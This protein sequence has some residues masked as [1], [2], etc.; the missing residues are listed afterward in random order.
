MKRI[1]TFIFALAAFFS[2]QAQDYVIEVGNNFFAPQN[3]VV[4]VGETVQWTNTGGFHNVN[5][6]TD[7]YPDNPEGFINGVASTDAWTFEYTFTVP[8]TYNYQCDPHAG[9]GM[10]GVITVEAAVNNTSDIVITEIMYNS[11][12]SSDLEFIELYNNTAAPIDM[13]DWSFASGFEYVFPATTLGAGE[14]LVISSDATMMSSNYGVSSLGWTDG[15]LSNGG[16]N[17][18]LVDAAMNP[19]DSVDYDDNS[20]GWPSIADGHGP[21]LVLCDVNSDNND[22]ANWQ[23][24]STATNYIENCT[25][26]FANP[27]AASSCGTL[28]IVTFELICAEVAENEGIMFVDLFIDN[29]RDIDTPVEI[30]I[31][32]SSTA[33]NGEDFDLATPIT[34]IFPAGTDTA[35]TISFPIIDDAIMDEGAETIVLTLSSVTDDVELATTTNTITIGDNDIE[36]TNALRLTGVYDGPLTGGVPKGVE[37]YVSQDVPDLSIFGLGS[38]NNGGGSD[39]QEYSFPAISVTAGTFLFVANDSAGFI[40]YFGLTPDYLFVEG[41]AVNVNGDDAIELFESNQVIDVFGDINVDGNG[42][43]WEYLDSWAYR[44]SATGPDG[45]TFV[46]DNWYFGGVDVFD[47]TTVN[48]DAASPYPISSYMLD[49]G[50]AIIASD[51]NANAEL[52]TAITINVLGND[53]LPNDVTSLMI[54]QN[55]AIGTAVVNG[56]NTITYTPNMDECGDD[57]ITYEVCDANGCDQASVDISVACPTTYPTA[58]IAE[59]TGVNDQGVATSEGET[60]ELQGI[61]HGVD[62]R[63]GSGLQFSL[64]DATGGIA[65]FSF[66]IEYYEAVEGDEL[67]VRGTIGQFSGLTQINPDT[68]IL[69]T[70][71]NDLNTPMVVTELNEDTESELIKIENLTIVDPAE[72]TN[73]GSGF[74]VNVTDGTNTYAMRIDNDSNIFG[75]DVPDFVFN[76]TGIGGQFDGDAP[77]DEGYQ[78]LPRYLDDIDPVTSVDNPFVVGEMS[79]FPNPFSNV[80]SL[81]TDLAWERLEVTNV[82]GQI[83]YTNNNTAN[84]DLNLNNLSSG[85]YYLTVVNGEERWT[86]KVV[87]Q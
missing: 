60:F 9:A 64:I 74:N 42:T 27:G 86:T 18:I 51:D 3:Q 21:S 1:F 40:S 76:L 72:W 12:N 61:V 73:D 57:V 39:D 66:D 26:V 68:I 44:K 29:P 62:F 11:P 22:P 58:T 36:L 7:T 50:D 45:S 14:Y 19:V 43:P 55:G 82:L 87:K 70:T 81:K 65:L 17:I 4:M 54:T 10:F 59:V 13:T 63:G 20:D 8:G 25:E 52:N 71:G 5:G 32:A 33:T 2:L 77:F 49:L 16:E 48:A 38:A 34:V 31:D 80:L 28:P 84:T 41:S 6:H 83:V 15:G 47:G 30:S 23:R 46:L 78:I 35:Q 69:A 79:V 24:A 75:T 53:V 85:V 37:V 56:D 67:I